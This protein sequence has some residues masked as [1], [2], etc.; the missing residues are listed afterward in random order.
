MKIKYNAP[1]TFTYIILTALIL[2]ISK[3]AIGLN[4]PGPGDI[5]IKFFNVEG[6]T[7]ESTNLLNYI[8]FFTHTFGHYDWYHLSTNI[9]YLVLLGPILE[10][11]YESKTFLGIL[12]GTSVITGI[13][14]AL[15]Q[16]PMIFGAS[17]LVYMMIMLVAF[18]RL[19][20]GGN[21]Y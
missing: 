14:M 4:N 19:K 10:E 20:P 13:F 21:P 18:V 8:S 3:M 1:V 16:Q 17:T 15:F 12:I 5:I 7:F 6:R 9:F 11:K 2:L